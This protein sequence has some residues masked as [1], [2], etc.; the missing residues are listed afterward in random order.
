MLSLPERDWNAVRTVLLVDDERD[1]LGLYSDVLELMG[2]RVL[3]AH[4]GQEALGLLC[5]Q[6]PDLV[7]TDWMMPRLDG[8]DLCRL[9]S[10]SEQ[11]RCIP[12]LLQSSSGNPQAPGAWAFL[13]KPCELGRFEEVVTR[14]LAGA[15]CRLTPGKGPRVGESSA[16]SAPR[17]GA[18]PHG[19]SPWPSHDARHW[20]E[21]ECPASP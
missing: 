17:A 1:M 18:H 5:Q 14:L 4:D 16:P 10:G 3:V 12:I 13:P 19:R 6:R 21:G 7:V 20:E 11:F 8:V 2:H 9:L 15:D